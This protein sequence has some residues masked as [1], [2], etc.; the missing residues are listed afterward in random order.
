MSEELKPCPKCGAID[1]YSCAT[2]PAPVTVTVTTVL[3]QNHSCDWQGGKPIC[4]FTASEVGEWVHFTDLQRWLRSD[5]AP[6]PVTVSDEAVRNACDA[7]DINTPD[8]WGAAP[9][10]AMRAALEAYESARGAGTESMLPPALCQKCSKPLPT[11]GPYYLACPCQ[12]TPADGARVA[13]D[14]WVACSERMPE[15][16]AVVVAWEPGMDRAIAAWWH[17]V[18]INGKPVRFW[19]QDYS[20]CEADSGRYGNGATISA[21]DLSVTHWRPLPPP[22]TAKAREE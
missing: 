21:R 7:F 3:R 6:A 15:P 4:R 1:V 17:D 2:P 9:R 13:G 18:P 12:I 22:P 5:P 11:H 16:H 10:K 14:G 19:H 20:E 8:E